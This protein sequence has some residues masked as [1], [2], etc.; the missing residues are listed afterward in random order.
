MALFDRILVPVDGSRPSEVGSALAIELAHAYGGTLLFVNIV[1]VG[2]WT[3]TTSFDVVDPV[4]LAAEAHDSGIAL[5]NSAAASAQANGLSAEAVVLDGP[6]LDRLLD[7][8]VELDATV[9]VMGSHGRG[10]LARLLMRSRTDGLLRRSTVP[11]IVAPR[12]TPRHDG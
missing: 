9:V 2:V 7:A 8:I 6:V 12:G 11:V 4:A 10:G 1:D 3:D 5:V